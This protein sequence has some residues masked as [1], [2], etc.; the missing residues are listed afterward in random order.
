M[1]PTDSTRDA[2]VDRVPHH[3]P[4]ACSEPLVSREIAVHVRRRAQATEARRP[5]TGGGPQD[6]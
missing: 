6:M 2:A 1:T 3:L 5:S 4:R